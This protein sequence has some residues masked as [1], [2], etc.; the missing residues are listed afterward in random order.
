VWGLRSAT[1]HNRPTGSRNPGREVQMENNIHV[2]AD[3]LKALAER[4]A[5]R[6]ERETKNIGPN[7]TAQNIAYLAFRYKQAAE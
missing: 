7:T 2:P 3:R 1:A 5:K 6:A 4:M